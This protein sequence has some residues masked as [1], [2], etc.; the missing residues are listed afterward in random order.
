MH[1]KNQKTEYRIKYF[2][3]L[4][5]DAMSHYGKD[6]KCACVKCGY[7]DNI[8]GL[9]LDHINGKGCEHRR[10][11]KGA[12][13]YLWLKHNNYPEGLQTLCGTCHRIKTH[14]DIRRKLIHRQLQVIVPTCKA[15][16]LVS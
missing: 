6:G 15:V 1:T 13:M 16:M 9:E 11:L 5:E 7:S 10:N 8:D 3:Q 2:T 12:T 4:K 14:D